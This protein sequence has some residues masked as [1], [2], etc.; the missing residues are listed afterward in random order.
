MILLLG[1][2]HGN[3]EYLKHKINT[4]KIT[5]CSIIQVGDFGIGFTSFEN[6][7]NIL[8]NLNDFLS[9]KNITLYAIRGNHDNPD[10]FRGDFIFSN[11][12]LVP[13]YTVLQLDGRNIL[14]IGG[15]ISIDRKPRIVE[16][17]SAARYGSAR[18]KYWHDEKIV[19]KEDFIKT[20]R[21]VDTLVT[22]TAMDFCLPNNKFGFGSL[23]EE[24]AY[25]D[26]NLKTELTEEREL[27]T[28][29]WDE[30]C[31]NNKITNHFYGHFHRS[32]VERIVDCEHRLLNIDEL[33]EFR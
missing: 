6:D 17:M 2:I 4:Y 3:F 22:H 5:D 14:C 24:F 25:D 9:N 7:K 28:K 20:V 23:V 10:F 30:L 13:D 16:D 11:L 27:M 29:I 12:E 18:R 19:Y 33:F 15:A 31:E 1:D 32:H 8:A 21:N 26:K